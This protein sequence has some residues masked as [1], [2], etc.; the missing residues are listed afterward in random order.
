MITR[1]SPAGRVGAVVAEDA[2]L[3]PASFAIAP[4]LR[5]A[6]EGGCVD[7][8]DRRGFR[9]AGAHARPADRDLSTRHQSL[10]ASFWSRLLSGRTRREFQSASSTYLR[11]SSH[12]CVTLYFDHLDIKNPVS[13]F[14]WELCL[15]SFHQCLGIF[16]FSQTCLRALKNP[17]E[18]CPVY[19]D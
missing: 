4:R 19:V 10:W 16:T 17:D 5:A 7:L 8:L 6:E 15:C 2:Q 12:I 3:D 9:N 11:L 14:K 13:L 1:W 18:T